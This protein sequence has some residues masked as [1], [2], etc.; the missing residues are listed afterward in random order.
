MNKIAVVTATRAEYGLLTPLIRRIDNDNDLQL[1]LIVTGAHLSRKFGNTVEFIVSDGLPISYRV[2]I[3]EHGNSALDISYTIANAIKGFARI[4]SDDKPDML[5]VLGDRYEMLGVAIAAM[6]ENIPIAHIHGGEITIGA[7][8][9]CIRHSITKMSYLHFTSTEEYRRRV[10]QLGESP[11]RVFNVG[12]LSVENIHNE[13]L[14]SE[15]AVRSIL[16][17]EKGKYAIGTFH[18]VTLDHATAYQEVSEFCEAM[19]ECKDITFVVTMANADKGGDCINQVIADYATENDNIVSVYNLGMKNYLSAVKYARFVIGNSS[20]GI[21]EAPILGTPTV[22]IG[23]R[24]K[25]RIMCET[26]INCE[27]NKDSIISAINK[28]ESMEHIVTDLYGDGNTSIKIV[29]TIKCFLLN[30]KIELKKG[31]YTLNG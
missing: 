12:A 6:N 19:K 27:I 16:G 21:T 31:F 28:A 1:E 18:P 22:N 2:E 26:I 11:N 7:I 10:I 20:S 29:E 17:V 24:Q 8:D 30:D 14:L 13:D 15:V 3:L 25:G 5:V 9:D 23:D 4:F